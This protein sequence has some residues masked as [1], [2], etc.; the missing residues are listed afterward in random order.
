[1]QPRLEKLA[2][3]KSTVTVQVTQYFVTYFYTA[4]DCQWPNNNI[5][6][7]EE[8]I[9]IG[10]HCTNISDVRAC[11]RTLQVFTHYNVSQDITEF[12]YSYYLVFNTTGD[13]NRK[14]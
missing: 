4:L 5:H 8:K 7:D 3:I 10:T 11:K 14:Q 1:M 9:D 12:L 13:I 2:D 6:A